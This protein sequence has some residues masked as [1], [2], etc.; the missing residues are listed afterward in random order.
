M[1]KIAVFA[2]GGGTNFQALIDEIHN[3]NDLANIELLFIDRESAFAK[4]RAKKNH[5]PWIY[6]GKEK[7]PDFEAKTE[8]ILQNL[9]DHEIDLIVLA[10][11]LGIIDQKI[12]KRYDRKIINV[13]PSLIPKYCGK[14]FYGM[15]IHEAV[16]S[17]KERET[18]VTIHFVDEGIDT[19]EIIAQKKIV[20]D[21]NDSAEKLSIKVL[22]IEHEILVETVKKLLKE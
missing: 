20:I 18:G 5:I 7:F 6:I 8:Y 15:K 4:E 11:F 17:N 9:I 13:H 12:I 16:V 19:G 1:K 21:E 14:G 3:K 2:S 22:K 10:G